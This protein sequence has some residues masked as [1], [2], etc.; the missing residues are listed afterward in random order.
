M[1]SGN[2]IG[3]TDFLDNPVKISKASQNVLSSFTFL[4]RPSA[5]IEI[6]SLDSLKEPLKN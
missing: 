1:N 3:E 6:P 2:N 4:C 5:A